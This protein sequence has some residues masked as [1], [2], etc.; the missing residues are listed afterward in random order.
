MKN[1]RDEFQY[2]QVHS[3]QS[4]ITTLFSST[5]IP[6]Q[7]SAARTGVIKG[8]SIIDVIFISTTQYDAVSSF[9]FTSV[10]SA[11]RWTVYTCFRSLQ[12]KMITQISKLNKKQKNKKYLKAKTPHGTDI[13][14]R[15][16]T[17]MIGRNDGALLAATS[18]CH[19]TTPVTS[20]VL[21]HVGWSFSFLLTFLEFFASFD[22]IVAVILALRAVP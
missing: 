18:T 9:L 17:K 11:D 3:C 10:N 15:N 5:F 13:D 14:T 20:S 22:N 1:S 16:R 2:L 6:R 12:S 7:I 4:L 8:I 19:T 21:I